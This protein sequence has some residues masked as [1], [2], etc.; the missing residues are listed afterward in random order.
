MRTHQTKQLMS[1]MVQCRCIRFADAQCPH[2]IHMQLLHIGQLCTVYLTQQCQ[3]LIQRV[4]LQV[5]RLHRVGNR[6][7]YNNRVT[8]QCENV[9]VHD[10]IVSALTTRESL[11]CSAFVRHSV[12]ETSTR[13]ASFRLGATDKN[14][15]AVTVSP[16]AV[17]IYASER[18]VTARLIITTSACKTCTTHL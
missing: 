10:L 16:L 1:D 11:V 6:I 8:H 14:M 12:A 17:G 7:A 9:G 13:L 15:P 18:D 4:T 2:R 5:K 3:L